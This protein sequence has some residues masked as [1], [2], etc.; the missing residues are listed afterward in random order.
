M[1]TYDHNY[2]S[3]V[4]INNLKHLEEI[5]L[6]LSPNLNCLVGGRGTGKSTIIE[7]IKNVIYSN[8]GVK[9]D[10]PQLLDSIKRY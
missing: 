10:K 6:R 5:N 3:G 8:N 1:N 4:K 2:I 9:Y 7:M